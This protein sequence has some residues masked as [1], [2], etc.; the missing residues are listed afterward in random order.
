MRPPERP[1]N[2]NYFI[3]RSNFANS[4]VK[5]LK[6]EN[7]LDIIAETE[8]T[9]GTGKTTILSDLYLTIEQ[10]H[11]DLFPV[12]MSLHLYSIHHLNPALSR[13]GNL[14]QSLQVLV[15]NYIS[16]HDLILNLCEVLA[17]SDAVVRKIN[18]TSWQSCK[19]LVN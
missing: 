19:L 7:K 6:Q 12:W 5:L 15:Q 13:E 18:K 11:K 2:V 17:N 9:Y 1:R 16:Y 8:A 10:Q 4:F 14:L 3:D